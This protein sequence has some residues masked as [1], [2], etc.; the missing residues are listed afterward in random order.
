MTT[1]ATRSDQFT[2]WMTETDKVLDGLT[3]YLDHHTEHEN[4]G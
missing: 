3:E 4:D 1:T 2:D